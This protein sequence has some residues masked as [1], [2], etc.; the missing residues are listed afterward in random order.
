MIEWNTHDNRYE[1]T[2]L[3][4]KIHSVFQSIS[5]RDQGVLGYEALCRIYMQGERVN[6]KRFFKILEGFDENTE[7]R[8][9]F[10][11]NI[12]H[13]R[14][15]RK[16][17][18][19]NR[20]VK[21][22]LNLTLSFFKYLSNN[23]GLE[24]LYLPMINKEDVG[25]NQIVMEIVEE[26]CPASDIIHLYSGTK[27]LKGLGVSFALDDFGT[28]WSGYSRMAVVQ[29]EYIKVSREM[30]VEFGMTQQQDDNLLEE[31]NIITSLKNIKVIFEGI[32]NV[33]NYNVASKYGAD[34]F[35]GYYLDIPKAY[36]VTVVTKDR[37]LVSDI[38]IKSYLIG[39][40]LKSN[41]S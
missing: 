17:T 14:N 38:E 39:M 23:D 4:F 3:G 35:Q 15:F 5:C 34:F 7:F 29:P 9:K 21:I 20:N 12:M 6:V 18:I 8:L 33:E 26:Y 27:Y 2:V 30:L 13:L 36:P 16:S 37:P 32:E 40:S 24:G 19:Y 28:G 22:F 1:M 11:M 25:L 31:L 10:Y 41:N